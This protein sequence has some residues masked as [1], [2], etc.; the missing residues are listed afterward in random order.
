M[1]KSLVF[2]SIY[3]KKRS[4]IYGDLRVFIIKQRSGK[5]IFTIIPPNFNTKEQNRF[6]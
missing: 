5:E 3:G 1:V 2:P 4:D 6:Y